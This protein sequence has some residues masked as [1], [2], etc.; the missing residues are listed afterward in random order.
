MLAVPITTEPPAAEPVPVDGEL[1]RFVN[2]TFIA[3]HLRARQK[4]Y[5]DRYR[6]AVAMLSQAVGRPAVI[7]DL[8]PANVRR[9]RETA[10]KCGCGAWRTKQTSRCLFAVAQVAILEGRLAGFRDPASAAPS[11]SLPAFRRQPPNPGTLAH[12]WRFVVRP[13]LE[14][15]AGAGRSRNRLNTI[16]AAVDQFDAL[17]E[18]Y[19]TPDDLTAATL[20]DFR[21]ALMSKG[22]AESTYFAYATALRQVA[23]SIAP[24]TFANARRTVVELPPPAPGSVRRFFYDVYSKTALVGVTAE[25][26]ADY[27][28]TLRLF[29]RCHGRDVLLAELRDTLAG[30]F[31]QWL[32]DSGKNAA[33]TNGHRRRLRALWAAAH[34]RGDAPPLP[35]MRKLRETTEAPDAFTEQEMA[36][37]LAAPAQIAWRKKIFGIEPD[38]WW[39]ALI[40]VCYWTGLRRRSLLRL[41][42]EDVDLDSGWLYSRAANMKTRGGGRFRIGEDARLAIAE[43]W[44]P[45]RELLFAWPGDPG[46][47]H[48]DLRRIIAVAGVSP[49][50]RKTVNQ[51]HRIRRTTATFAT[52]R[53]GLDAA[54]RLLGHTKEA[55]TKKYVDERQLPGHDATEFLPA[56]AQDLAQAFDDAGEADDL[57]P[58]FALYEDPRTCAQEAQRLFRKGHLIAAGMTARVALETHL[59][60]LA[61]P[62]RFGRCGSLGELTTALCSVGTIDAD[63][64]DELHRLLAVG[65]RVA[66]GRRLAAVQLAELIRTVY[67]LVSG[68]GDGAA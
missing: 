6:E 30:E 46:S 67:A 31:F 1:L 51:L 49:C 33:T 3:E 19:A 25:A 27:E 20:A 59:V 36:W 63:R 48:A 32:L 43:I 10:D 55:I 64:R 60:Q 18:R 23:R 53:K 35:R 12:A 57:L 2:D 47:F 13:Q 56:I 58:E 68:R 9:A 41:R 16:N 50:P 14:T 5:R 7:A 29:Y 62:H 22:R 40:L 34:D 37:L 54:A 21:Q 24:E 61:A 15:E 42:C 39:R 17:L 65:N 45:E 38:A 28:Y 8:T 4:R 26:V 52:V 44:L 11:I 66:H